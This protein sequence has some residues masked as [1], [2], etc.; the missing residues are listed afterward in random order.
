MS[1]IVVAPLMPLK[2]NP[3][4]HATDSLYEA[5]I[6]AADAG[7]TMFKPRFRRASSVHHNR[8]GLIGEQI[9]ASIEQKRPFTHVLFQDDDIVIPNDAIV[10]LVQA[11]KPIIGGLCTTRTDPPIP[12]ARLYDEEKE[13][14]ENLFE[15]PNGFVGEVD[16]LGT[17][18]LLISYEAIKE[19]A[20]VYLE[21]RY[22]KEVYGL[23][24]ARV[25]EMS[26]LRQKQFDKFPNAWWFRWLP[27]LSGAG[28]N[29]EDISFCWVAQRYCGIPTVVDTTI[30]PAH[31]GVYPYTIADFVANRADAIARAKAE[32]RY[33]ERDRKRCPIEFGPP[34]PK[35]EDIASLIE[36]VN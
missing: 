24:E 2:D 11:G 4:L 6:Q 14:W 5:S 8:N 25:Q 9:V 3:H 27:P 7:I 28:E 16:A 22:E 31:I 18:L 34:V 17:G 30:Q 19:V 20:Q 21:C 29:G 36:V 33:R 32:G 10:K 12:N 1:Q 15:W 13:I 35:H 26:A 23:T